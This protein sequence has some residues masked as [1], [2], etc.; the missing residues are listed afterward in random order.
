LDNIKNDETR[1]KL[2]H[3]TR[4]LAHDLF[5][6]STGN[7]SL[8]VT[9]TGLNNARSLL[10]P[11]LRKNLE[12]LNFPLLSGSSKEYDW[13]IRDLTLNGADI[14][15]DQVEVRLWSDA[16]VRFTEGTSKAVTYLTVWIRD[17]GITAS[18][19][20][21]HFKRKVFPSLD[22]FG[23]ANIKIYGNNQM[24][25]TWKV[26][27]ETDKPLDMKLYSLRCYI[28][29]FKIDFIESNHTILDK[30][31]IGLWH[32]SIKRRLEESVEN[33]V[34]DALFKLNIQLSESLKLQE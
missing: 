28:D 29:H 25:I 26:F 12:V 4:V 20:K 15:P 13:E 6:D 31:I 11:V 7:P 17:V 34:R 24:R 8:A 27:F 21:F 23:R 10:A 16:Q 22:T 1:K 9:Q 33:S 5:L 14:I 30:M 3:D 19:V 18:D 2:S 32:S